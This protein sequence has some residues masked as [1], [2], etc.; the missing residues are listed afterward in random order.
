LKVI[1]KWDKNK[2]EKYPKDTLRSIDY[3][4]SELDKSTDYTMKISQ[5]K[6]VG[7][8]GHISAHSG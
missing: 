7:N 4:Q 3:E 6:T 1:W 2:T 8:A 5:K